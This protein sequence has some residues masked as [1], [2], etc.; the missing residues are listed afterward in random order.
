MLSEQKLLVPHSKITQHCYLSFVS[1]LW[2]I[3]KF[4]NSHWVSL[5]LRESLRFLE[6]AKAYGTVFDGFI[7]VAS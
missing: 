2:L 1:F 6:A 5:T 4:V 3:V 7:L